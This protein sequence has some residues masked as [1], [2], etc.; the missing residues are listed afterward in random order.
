MEFLICELWLLKILCYMNKTILLKCADDVRSMFKE[1]G[2][3]RE[4]TRDEIRE[5]VRSN[6]VVA[7]PYGKND[8]PGATEEEKHFEALASESE[9]VTFM[10]EDGRDGFAFIEK[11]ELAQNDNDVL[12]YGVKGNGAGFKRVQL[13]LSEVA[14]PEAVALFIIAYGG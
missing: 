2:A 9:S 5:A 10:E 7:F 13:S 6:G 11:V 8:Y 4:K 1:L 14:N 3:M 12:L